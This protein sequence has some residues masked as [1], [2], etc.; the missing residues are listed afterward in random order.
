MIF[1]FFTLT[2]E[3]GKNKK[4]ALFVCD[5]CVPELFVFELNCICTRIKIHTKIST[6]NKFCSKPK[7]K[8]AKINTRNTSSHVKQN[9][10]TS[11]I[12]CPIKRE[13]KKRQLG[14][15]KRFFCFQLFSH[16]DLQICLRLVFLS[17]CK[18][19]PPRRRRQAASHLQS[20]VN[21]NEF[22]NCFTCYI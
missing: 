6:L 20:S 18:Q 5:F 17:L 8:N 11:F 21:K 3:L 4:Q 13:K 14:S 9:T 1:D 10:F 15:C 7:R 19:T 12:S 2:F 22:I 16:R